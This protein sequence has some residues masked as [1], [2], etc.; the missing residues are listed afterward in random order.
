[1]LDCTTAGCEL[2]DPGKAKS[3]CTDAC[4]AGVD[5]V[6]DSAGQDA[7]RECL[8]CLAPAYKDTCDLSEDAF[9]AC[10]SECLPAIEPLQIWVETFGKELEGEEVLCDDGTPAGGGNCSYSTGSDG[11]TETCTAECTSGDQ[12]AGAEC[13]RGDTETE[14]TCQCTSGAQA[15][16]TF[17]TTSDCDNLGNSILWEVCN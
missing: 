5:A 10:Q 17:Q 2:A 16:A 14:Y 7:I 15:G 4:E 1:V 6:P 8:G 13:Q 11:T 12:M 9:L 3:L